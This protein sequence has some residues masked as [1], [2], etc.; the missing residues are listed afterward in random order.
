MFKQIETYNSKMHYFSGVTLFWPVQ[1][2]QPVVDVIKR[3]KS[4][5]KVLS[6]ATYNFI[7]LNTNIPH[8]KLNK[9]DEKVDQLLF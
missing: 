7:M 4:R 1:I 2:S 5:S 3:R 9:C 6:I 8:N